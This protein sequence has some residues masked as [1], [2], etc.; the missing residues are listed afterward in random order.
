[1]DWLSTMDMWKSYLNHMESK[2]TCSNQLSKKFCLSGV[3]PVLLSIHLAKEPEIYG[4]GGGE[5]TKQRMM[6]QHSVTSNRER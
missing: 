1:M 2:P 6:A 5:R 4:M 3:I